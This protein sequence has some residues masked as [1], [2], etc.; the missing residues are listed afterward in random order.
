MQGKVTYVTACK[1]Y[2]LSA[3]FHKPNKNINTPELT[4]AFFRESF[5][6]LWDKRGTRLW[7]VLFCIVQ[8]MKLHFGGCEVVFKLASKQSKYWYAR[9]DEEAACFCDTC[10]FFFNDVAMF[11]C[12]QSIVRKSC[13]STWLC[14]PSGGFPT[15]GAW[16]LSDHHFV[17]QCGVY[18]WFLAEGTFA[19][20]P[21]T[22]EA[23]VV[24]CAARE[25]DATKRTVN[26]G[27]IEQFRRALVCS[28]PLVKKFPF[29]PIEQR[30]WAELLRCAVEDVNS[31]GKH[32]KRLSL[33]PLLLEHQ[34]VCSVYMEGELYRTGW[35]NETHVA[36]L[37]ACW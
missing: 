10:D 29:V 13:A 9:L 22:V 7:K 32:E 3:F 17:E 15:A 24:F 21:Q 5:C 20:C 34:L 4:E 19:L 1:I 11:L 12:V 26:I 33:L 30:G 31:F 8:V 35:S 25:K 27:R 28:L 37:F 18:S 14:N 2:I 36:F 6:I 23:F 16:W